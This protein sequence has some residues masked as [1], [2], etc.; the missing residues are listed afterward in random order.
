MIILLFSKHIL[1]ALGQ[2]EETAEYGMIYIRVLLPGMFAMTQFETVRRYLQ[3]MEIFS[4][5][6]GI[7]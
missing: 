1:L 2:E 7:Q 4:L 5:S 3:G 6:M